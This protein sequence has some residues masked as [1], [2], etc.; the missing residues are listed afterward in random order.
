MAPDLMSHAT[1]TLYVKKLSEDAT[2]PIKTSEEASG[3]DM[4]SA[5]DSCVPANG[6]SLIPTDIAVAVTRGKYAHIAPRSGLAA[7]HFISVE[8]GVVG[9]DYRENVK[10]LL[11]NHGDADFLVSKL[12]RIAAIAGIY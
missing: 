1:T 10:V 6:Q 2:F 9:A 8:A 3:F 12:D 11:F 4:A 7:K 5:V